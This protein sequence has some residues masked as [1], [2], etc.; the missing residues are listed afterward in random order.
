MEKS[1]K[2][3]LV[4]RLGYSE[5]DVP[6]LESQLKGLHELLLP[7]Y[8][9]WV[10]TGQSS[11]SRQYEGYS[12]NSLQADYGMNFIAALLTLDWLLKEPE[13]ARQ[14]LRHYIL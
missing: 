6:L 2:E 12:L 3:L 8:Q 1:L 9:R 11:D 14:A 4:E 13:Q 5:Q 7:L 10:E